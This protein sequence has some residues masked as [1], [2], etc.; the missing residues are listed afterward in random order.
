MH[1]CFGES[2]MDRQTD[3]PTKHRGL[4]PKDRGTM[5]QCLYPLLSGLIAEGM[6]RSP[7]G[8]LEGRGVLRHRF[9]EGYTEVIPAGE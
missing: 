5:H 6:D 7:R 2:G 4:T 3:T 8:I 1:N 9:A